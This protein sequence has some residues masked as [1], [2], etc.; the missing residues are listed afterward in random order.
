[1]TTEASSQ[2][3]AQEC[4]RYCTRHEINYT[5]RHV[6]GD[7]WSGCPACQGDPVTPHERG[8]VKSLA[9]VAD[10]QMPT[11][12]AQCDK[13]G[14]FTSRNYLG[15]VWSRC[16]KCARETEQAEREKT[17][18]LEVEKRDKAWRDS[19]GCA[20]IPERFQSCTL[21]TYVATNEGQRHAL[22]FATAYAA[23]FHRIMRTGRGALFLGMPGTGKTH[24]ACGIALK[25]ME[26]GEYVALFTTV[27][28]A[29]RRV[30]DTWRKGSKESETQAIKALVFPHLLIL[31]EIGVQ[32]GSET[33]KNIIMDVIN[34]RYEQRKP[35]IMLSNLELEEV[36]AFIGE[37]VFD[38]LREDGGEYIPFTWGSHRGS[39]D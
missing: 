20:L 39:G 2:A 13:H 24:L 21:D 34:E 17:K 11:R 28:R 7:A 35:T 33:E 9:K 3:G 6:I 12:P 36:K 16:Q 8:Q 15:N 27:M 22:A 23:D 5:S 25:I 38:R 26:G 14:T 10:R 37:R 19:L 4:P 31:D 18:R 32:F 1:M 30:K 29:M